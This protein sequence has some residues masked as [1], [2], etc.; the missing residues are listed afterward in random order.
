MVLMVK[1]SRHSS[2]YLAR[3]YLILYLN[4]DLRVLFNLMTIKENIYVNC[5][6]PQSSY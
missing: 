6:V 4:V 3:K 5:I 2:K 1:K